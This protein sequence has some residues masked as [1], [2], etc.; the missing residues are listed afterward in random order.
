MKFRCDNKLALQ[1]AF[2]QIA[3]SFAKTGYVEITTT[4][5]RRTNQQND[6]YWPWCRQIAE[7]RDDGTSEYDVDAEVKLEK[8]FSLRR[9]HDAEFDEL[10][11]R[12]IDKLWPAGGR[13]DL[14]HDLAKEMS[15][16]S[17]L[18]ADSFSRLLEWM[19]LHFFQGM[20]I[21][22]EAR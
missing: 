8:G 7:A 13:Y 6:C 15:G 16:P 1:S 22:L 20:G 11:T 14:A 10:L 9:A 2:D 12:T 5:K 3:A 18:D 4:G 17:K 19:Q 21:R